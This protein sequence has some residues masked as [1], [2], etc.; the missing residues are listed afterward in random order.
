MR[1]IQFA[2]AIG[3]FFAFSACGGQTFEEQIMA[4]INKY[5]PSGICEDFPEGTVISNVK[6]GEIVDIGL[7]GMTDV[8]YEFDY[9]IDGKQGHEKSAML[10]IKRGSRYTLASLGG[11]CNYEMR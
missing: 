4:D 3:L 7:D 6:V 1:I 8:S 9:Q 10:Y 2:A 11:D 5:I